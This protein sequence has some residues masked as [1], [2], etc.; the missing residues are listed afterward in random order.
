MIV[1]LAEPYLK[2]NAQIL[3]PF[4]GVGTMLIERISVSGT[5]KIRN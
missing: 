3:D 4:C 5:G 1:A 2:E